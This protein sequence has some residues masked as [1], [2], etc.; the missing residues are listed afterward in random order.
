MNQSD[1]PA[2]AGT[3]TTPEQPA[4]YD[5]SV[6]VAM[7]GSETAV[8]ASVMQTFMAATRSGLDELSQAFASGDLAAVASVAHRITGASRMSGAYA[9]GHAARGAEQSA[10]QGDVNAVQQ[11]IVALDVQWLLLQTAIATQQ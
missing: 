11:A 3:V 7:F 10:Q 5:A 8:I 9:L 4:V 6:L 1:P 2:L